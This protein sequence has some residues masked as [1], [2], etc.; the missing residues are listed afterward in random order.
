M[1]PLLVACLLL[2]LPG[3][4]YSLS[5]RGSYLPPHIKKIGVPLFA[6]HTSVFEV[7][8]RITERV[9][10][11]LIGRGRYTIQPDRTGVDAVL[12]GEIVAILVAPAAF[13]QQ[14]QATR[15]TVTLVAK[16]EFRDVAND[17][18]LWSNPSMQVS[19]QYDVATT[20]AAVDPNAFLG[21]NVN[22][23]E[24]LSSEFARSLVSAIL[25]SF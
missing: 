21:Q 19:E 3:C 15:Y 10:S 23:I 25:E 4:G 6:N 20:V 14:Q 9:R 13:N 8:Q 18:V 12:I 24:R 2:S 7:E 11:E 5:G 1:G 17:K 22:A 16:V